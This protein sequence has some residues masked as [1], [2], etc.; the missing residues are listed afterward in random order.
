MVPEEVPAP[1]PAP[2]EPRTIEETGLTEAFLVNLTLK[3]LYSEGIDS[4][5]QVANAMRLTWNGLMDHI[6]QILAQDQLVE[7]SGGKGFGRAS[8]TFKLTTKGRDAA[9]DAVSRSGYTGPAPVP[10]AQYCTHVIAQSA[11]PHP[12]DRAA[13]D[14]ATSHLVFDNELLESVGPAMA[15]GRALFLF[16]DP[17]NGKTA[18]SEALS[19]SMGGAVA[20]PYAIEVDGQVIVVYDD[21]WHIP[22][23]QA[24]Q[25]RVPGV[26]GTDERWVICRRPFL[27]VGG[28]LT[29]DMLDLAHNRTSNVYE[30]PCQLKANGGMLLVDDFGRQRTSAREMLN[31]WIIP[32]EKHVDMLALQSGRKFEVPMEEMVVFSTNLEPSSLVDEAF[33]RRIKYKV[34]MHNPSEAQF[35]EI[36][37]RLC[38]A[39]GITYKDSAIDWLL[40]NHYA[41]SGRPLRS[42]QPR[43]LLQ[44]L[45]DIATFKCVEP[46]LSPS[47]LD[48]ACEMYFS[49]MTGDP[50]PE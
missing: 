44:I 23:E 31:R 27:V 13:L 39:Q 36:F 1:S 45:S 17:G 30:A 14:E 49:T 11:E 2:A 41:P 18:L 40:A 6:F 35:R 10:L 8:V 28:E 42:C 33:L 48:H 34:H 22:H 32:L 3:H 5:I 29:L 19:Q 12:V 16:G 15:S 21:A 50:K 20:I 46:A 24:P 47:L 26:A 38:R 43:D 25:E 7:L 37:R 9:R 4:G